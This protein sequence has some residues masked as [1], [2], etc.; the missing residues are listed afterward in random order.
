MSRVG[1][2]AGPTTAYG[3]PLSTI[4]PTDNDITPTAAQAEADRAA[5][6]AD[7]LYYRLKNALRDPNGDAAPPGEITP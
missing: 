6:L 2:F 1:A 5:A 3:A 7:E 4:H